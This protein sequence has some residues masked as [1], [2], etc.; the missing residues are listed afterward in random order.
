MSKLATTLALI[1]AW[2]VLLVSLVLQALFIGIVGTAGSIIG[3]WLDDNS[4]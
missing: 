3:V 2:P 1:L 4:Y